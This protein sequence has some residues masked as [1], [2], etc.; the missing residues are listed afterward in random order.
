IDHISLRVTDVGRSKA[1]YT[2]VLATLGY[3]PQMDFGDIVGY[4]PKG[5]PCFWLTKGE[6]VTPTHIAFASPSREAAMPFYETALASGATDNGKP[7]LRP[8]YHKDYYGAFVIDP[9]GHNIEAVIRT[10]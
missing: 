1:F 10:A 8:E 9:D 6:N 2:A 5:R 4:G 7:G 3:G